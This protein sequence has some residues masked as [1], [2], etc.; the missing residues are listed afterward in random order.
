ME[1]VPYPIKGAQ[2]EPASKMNAL[3]QAYIS[4]LRLEGFSLMADMVY[5]S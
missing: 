2:D 3:L 4:K 5:I 1:R